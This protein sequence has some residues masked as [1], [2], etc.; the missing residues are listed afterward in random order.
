MLLP[1]SDR[2]LAQQEP[3]RPDVQQAFEVY[4]SDDALQA[5]YSRTMSFGDLPDDSRVRGGFFINEE[6]DLI[7][8]GE[9]VIQ[10]LDTTR[11]SAWSL[12]VGPRAYGALL[13]VEDQD[14][15]SI[16]LGGTIR[17]FFDRQRR[18]SVGLTAY[19]APDIVTFGNADELTDLSVEIQT[20]LTD[21]MDIFLGYRSF[22][23]DLDIPDREVDD[24]VHLGLRGRL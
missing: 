8:M 4:L 2:V 11:R 23:I 7:G 21:R 14:I 13:S 12:E 6:R 16:A 20:R 17:Y 9:M 18:T 5:L 1:L 22:E 15:F 3:E 10:V 24:G 19:Y